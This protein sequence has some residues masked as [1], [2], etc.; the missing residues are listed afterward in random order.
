MNLIDFEYTNENLALI[1]AVYPMLATIGIL[2]L[3]KAIGN[4]FFLVSPTVSYKTS[5]LS[6]AGTLSLLRGSL[7]PKRHIYSDIKTLENM[8]EEK[9]SHIPE[10]STSN[11]KK[12]G[13]V[14][15]FAAMT[16]TLGIN[17][18]PLLKFF[19]VFTV[20]PYNIGN[21]LVDKG[22]ADAFCIPAN[23][24]EKSSYL[25]GTLPETKKVFA[26]L[27][28]GYRN[29][30]LA[31]FFSGSSDFYFQGTYTKSELIVHWPAP[32]TEYC[33]KYL[34]YVQSQYMLSSSSFPSAPSVSLAIKSFAFDFMSQD[35]DIVLMKYNGESQP[36]ADGGFWN[37]NISNKVT[38]PKSE[39][40]DSNRTKSPG[41]ILFHDNV[42]TYNVQYILHYNQVSEMN[43][44]KPIIDKL[45]SCTEKYFS[46]LCNAAVITTPL[47]ASVAGG[48]FDFKTSESL[49]D[50]TLNRSYYGTPIQRCGVLPKPFIKY[51]EYQD[52]MGIG[53]TKLNDS[54]V[55]ML[56]VLMRSSQIHAIQIDFTIAQISAS[57]QIPGM[58]TCD[59]SI[60]DFMGPYP[61]DVAHL[62]TSNSIDA[63]FIADDLKNRICKVVAT[64]DY[65]EIDDL[66]KV[67]SSVNAIKE[68]SRISI[69]IKFLLI[70]LI[71]VVLWLI[72]E[73]AVII[74]A[75]YLITSSSPAVV[76][77]FSNIVRNPLRAFA[78]LLGANTTI[79][80]RGWLSEPQFLRNEFKDQRQEMFSLDV[81]NG[82]LVL[83]LP[84]SLVAKYG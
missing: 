60:V 29:D 21:V 22:P 9:N 52:D 24:S 49:F 53:I 2:A 48:Y 66:T 44:S 59:K 12:P 58:L 78:F 80:Q 33:S 54:M 55:R 37:G 47:D 81:E 84:E 3:I 16:M 74:R 7:L 75:R 62:V 45:H 19:L 34:C 31:I 38:I 11:F 35:L 4:I 25:Y 10:R 26:D 23:S 67:L 76:M 50:E 30:S 1:N 43:Q 20:P 15:V 42:I 57:F 69:N 41:A 77:L 27:K 5:I 70:I 51:L 18:L 63:I 56:I 32:A 83:N 36:L 28:Y 46:R 73:V 17:S 13:L 14:L 82:G 79:G 39:L 71:V 65:P 72:L 40:L 64:P 68:T 6:S 8:K 61:C